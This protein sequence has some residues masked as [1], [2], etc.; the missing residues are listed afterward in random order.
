MKKSFRIL[1]SMLMVLA[2]TGSV[3]QIAN[4][5]DT[6]PSNNIYK[7]AL[8]I[9]LGRVQPAAHEELL[10][11]G[12]VYTLLQASGELANKAA[13]AKECGLNKSLVWKGTIVP[14]R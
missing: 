7:R 4:S 8:D 1:L 11:S 13:S 2:V 10:S 6:G 5:Q 9:E 3:L 12:I 14:A